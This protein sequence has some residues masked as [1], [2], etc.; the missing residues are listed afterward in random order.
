MTTSSLDLE[1]LDAPTTF[2][3]QL[4]D[5][6]MPTAVASW[7]SLNHFICS[8]TNVDDQTGL[9][10]IDHT[11]RPSTLS[12]ANITPLARSRIGYSID[13]LK[14]APRMMV[15]TNSTLW[16]HVA[17]YDE[18][19]PKLL[20]DA[21]AACALYNARNDTN[22][23]FVDRH[24]IS[25][26]D[27]LI[28]TPLPTGLI[29]VVAHAHALM[30][31]QIML[32][33]GG[34]MRFC[35]YVESLMPHL[36]EVGNLLLNLSTQQTDPIDPLPLYPSAAA[37]TAW[38]SFVLRETLRRTILSL[39]QSVALCHMLCGRLGS[40]APHLSRGNKVTLSAHLWSAKNAFDFAIA[41]NEKKHFLVHDLDFTEVLNDAQPDDIDDFAKTMLVGLLGYDDVKG[42]FYTKRGTFRS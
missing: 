40:C 3:D 4:L 14:L 16:S 8:P 19:M 23:D 22:A 1:Y 11:V 31:Y 24:I 37:R 33:F 21:Y 5:F 18:H 42:W 17:L 41:W 32:V 9:H 38:K 30:L 39:F 25:R 34:A 35:S 15:E 2:E 13:Q 6:D 7:N 29:E 28:A 36:E 10:N 12:W 27:E 20:Q 26:V